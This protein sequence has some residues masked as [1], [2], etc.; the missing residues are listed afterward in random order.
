MV[1]QI[2][3]R[4]HNFLFCDVLMAQC[5]PM[6]MTMMTN[7]FEMPL[8]MQQHV[9]TWNSIVQINDRNYSFSTSRFLLCAFSSSSLFF[10]RQILPILSFLEATIFHC[11]TAILHFF[12]NKSQL[13]RH[14]FLLSFWEI[15]KVSINWTHCIEDENRILNISSGR[16]HL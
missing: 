13:F 6:A 3:Q 15:A 4:C 10:L 2:Q 14:F 7:P 9:F 1:L 16:D 12:A 8:N 11:N 5:K